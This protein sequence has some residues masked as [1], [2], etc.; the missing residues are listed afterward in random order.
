MLT[1]NPNAPFMRN[2]HIDAISWQLQ[3]IRAGEI[4]R[5][6]INLPPR[7]LKSDGFGDF[8]GFSARP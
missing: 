7:Y 1:L 3:R 6:I 2:W 8:S 5:L 4:T